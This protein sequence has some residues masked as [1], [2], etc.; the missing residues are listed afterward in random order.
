MMALR[1]VRPVVD[2]V[3]AIARQGLLSSHGPPFAN[4]LFEIFLSLPRD[5]VVRAV[6]SLQ[7]HR[8]K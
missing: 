2:E 4:R 8:T 1:L 5:L 7:R 3:G 6:I